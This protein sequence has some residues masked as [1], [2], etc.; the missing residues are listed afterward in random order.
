MCI[1][2]NYVVNPTLKISIDTSMMLWIEGLYKCE[3][4]LKYVEVWTVCSYTGVEGEM[5]EYYNRKNILTYW[6]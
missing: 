5:K 4:F 6:N 2:E 1:L 3:L